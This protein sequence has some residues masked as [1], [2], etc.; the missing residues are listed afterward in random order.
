MLK[1]LM[2]KMFSNL[3]VKS[4]TIPAFST[5]SSVSVQSFGGAVELDLEDLFGH[6]IAVGAG[7]FQTNR[8]SATKAMSFYRQSS[9]VATAVDMIAQEIEGI[10]PVVKLPDGKLDDS[11]DILK[12][13]QNMNDNN[14]SYQKIIGTISRDWLLCHETYFYASGSVTRPP[15]ELF[16]IR[17]NAI[18][19]YDDGQTGYAQSY[20]ISQGYG[21]GQYSLTRN[22]GFGARYYSG[23]IKEIWPIIGYS[24][25]YGSSRA[26]SPLLSVCIEIYQQIKGRIHNVN[27]VEK[28]GRPSLLVMFNDPSL[29]QDADMARRQ[30]IREQIAGAENAGEIMTLT[31]KDAQVIEMSKNNKDM[32]YKNLDSIAAKA[33]YN[34]YHIPLPLITTD[35]STYNNLELAV[36]QLYHFAVI[37]TLSRIL[38]DLTMM[39]MPRFG[40][41]PY[42]YQITYNPEEIPALRR[43]RLDEMKLR[44]EIGVE[45]IN[46]IRS[47]IANREPLQGGDE[48]YQPAN[49]VP[50]GTDIFTDDNITL[51][52]GKAGDK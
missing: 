45:T 51:N 25:I 11:H 48:L 49:L 18:F 7:I 39:L 6:S 2:S 47:G 16:C 24:S 23:N 28:G 31:G 41:N 43:R 14:E 35:A 3:G 20:N 9:S 44:K 13:L 46:E 37:P 50:V 21:I 36:Y 27:L 42:E 29:D 19:A 52:P 4:K 12:L 1:S 10:Q 15:L 22:R 26:D 17:P 5:K 34:R 8:L 32:D 38:S 33:I 40:L 30:A